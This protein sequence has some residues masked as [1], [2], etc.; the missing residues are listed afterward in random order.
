MVV[1]TV[2]FSV[3]TTV[4]S[5]YL[6][7]LA[8]PIAA[9]I[10]IGSSLAWKFASRSG[11][12]RRRRLRRA[13]VGYGYW[14]LPSSGT[15]LPEWLAPLVFVLGLLA[16]GAL[17]VTISSPVVPLASPYGGCW[18]GRRRHCAGT[19]RGLGVGGRQQLGSLRYAVPVASCDLVQSAVLRCAA[20]AASRP[21]RRSRPCRNG[22]PD[23]MATQT[24]VLAA[25]LIFATGQEVLPIGGYTGT[26]PD[27]SMTTCARWWTLASSIWS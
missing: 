22:A 24:S 16:A 10:G 17:A 12:R 21:Y 13:H 20:E 18:H 8:P 2:V 1:L 15:G 14:L 19:A 6:A 27:P 11:R 25:S 9:L 4:N 23:L 26:I 3:S 5:Y 7:A